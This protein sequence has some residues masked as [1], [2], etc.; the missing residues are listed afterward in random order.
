MR[1]PLVIIN[2]ILLALC[3]SYKDVT[4]TDYIHILTGIYLPF[5]FIV[6]L[7]IFPAVT[8]MEGLKS[9]GQVNRS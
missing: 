8:I 1:K 2:R 3:T 9:G 5:E 6:Y 7:I 4:G